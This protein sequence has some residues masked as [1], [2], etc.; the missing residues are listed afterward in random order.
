MKKKTNYS[1]FNPQRN[2]TYD[3]VESDEKNTNYDRVESTPT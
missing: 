1:D 2:H 3:K